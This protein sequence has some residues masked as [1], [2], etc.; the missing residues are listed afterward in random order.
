M[1]ALKPFLAFALISSLLAVNANAIGKREKGALMGAGIMLLLPSMAQNM[2][3]LFNQK[4]TYDEPVR[5]QTRR[6]PVVVEREVIVKRPSR[7]RYNQNR[8]RYYRDNDDRQNGTQII[9][10][11]R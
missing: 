7:D 10:I 3:S 8:D 6:E 1:K 2:G 9:I 5:Y 11:E 4:E